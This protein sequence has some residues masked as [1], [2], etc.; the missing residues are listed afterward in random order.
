MDL[1]DTSKASGAESHAALLHYKNFRH[2]L[3][4]GRGSS[5]RKCAMQCTGSVSLLPKEYVK[6]QYSGCASITELLLHMSFVIQAVCP[7]PKM[8]DAHKRV[9]FR[10]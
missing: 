1:N 2:P 4:T 7:S 8:C 10:L 9:V 5:Y 3:A 6:A